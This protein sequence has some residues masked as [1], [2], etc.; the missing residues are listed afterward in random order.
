MYSELPADM[1]DQHPY[2]MYNE[3]KAQPQAVARSL[4]LSSH[5]TE[6]ARDALARARR[7]Y[8]TGCGTS[9]HAAR[10]G[11]EMIRTFTD[12]A[13]EVQAIQAYEFVTYLP[14]LKPEDAVV[15]LTHSGVTKMTLRA[16]A[17]AN[18]SRASSIVITGFADSAAGKAGTITI[19]SGYNDELSWAH[20]VSYTSALATLAAVGN[21]LATTRRRLDLSPL[22]E[23][24]AEA[25]QLEEMAH[26][27]AAGAL[28][29]ERFQEPPW[30]LIVGGGPN[31]ATAHEGVLKLLETSYVRAGAFELEQV[32]H[33][34]LAAA[35][36]GTMAILLC[37]AGRSTE[38]AA[39]LVQALLRLEITPVVI[40]GGDNQASFEDAHR[41][42]LPDLP[43]VLSPIPY[44]VPLQF[45]AYFLSVGKGYNPDLIHR[46]EERY[47]EAARAV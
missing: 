2:H 40:C 41:L 45:F 44:V 1:R 4:A 11:A 25:L 13:L 37:P 28:V 7:V 19:P 20:T 34:P 17:R 21:S 35:D 46:D 14:E 8:L 27:L 12:G 6:E 30:I 9:F 29:T 36:E 18:E 5:L 23:V 3:I 16:I 15:A 24:M 42:I 39:Q 38:R 33:G 31:E 32:L 22:P 10:A 26:R 47:R 43:E